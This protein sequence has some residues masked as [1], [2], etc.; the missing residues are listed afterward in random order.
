M[1]C[2]NIRATMRGFS[3]IEVLVAM[4][5]FAFGILGMLGMQARAIAYSS[6]AK[7]RTDATLLTDAL[8]NDIWVNRAN[9]ANYAYTGSGTA[10]AVMQP[11]LT[12]VQSTLPKGGASVTVN[13][14]QVT[15]SVTWQP[16]NDA[17]GAQHQHTEI[18]TIQN[19]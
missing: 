15:V 17:S 18:A 3:L 13:A 5:I 11:W 14:T 4:T 8:I 10:P 9:I 6:D 2:N 16:P 12:E 1:K 7:Y 19:P